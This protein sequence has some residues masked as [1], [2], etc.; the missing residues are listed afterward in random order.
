MIDRPDS[1]PKDL[2]KRIYDRSASAEDLIKYYLYYGC[3]H[4]EI[5]EKIVRNI[6]YSTLKEV[7]KEFGKLLGMNFDDLE[8]VWRG[9][10]RKK[11]N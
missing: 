7:Y 10:D 6:T 11:K 2:L 1:L 4:K 3:S 8:T 5:A 9:Y